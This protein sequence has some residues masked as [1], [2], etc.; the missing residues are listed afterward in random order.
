[1]TADSGKT[2]SEVI[3]NIGVELTTGEDRMIVDGRTI[4]EA[5]SD[6]HHSQTIAD[7]SDLRHSQTIAD[8]SDLRLLPNSV[9]R[10]DLRDRTGLRPHQE[11][12]GFSAS[13]LLPNSVDRRVPRNLP[14]SGHRTIVT[15]ATGVMIVTDAR[16]PVEAPAT[17][18]IEDNPAEHQKGRTIQFMTRQGAGLA[19]CFHLRHTQ[20]HHPA[21]I[22][23]RQ[24]FDN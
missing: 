2:G 16:C 6:L 21:L 11:L 3:V 23:A 20:K 13:R 4:G 9:D 24:L 8:R 12:A 7:R 1:M 19:P 15:I 17:G 5:R 22:I 10:Q 18:R 14:R